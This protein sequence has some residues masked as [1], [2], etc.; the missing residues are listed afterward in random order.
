MTYTATRL[1]EV[2]LVGR[3]QT[4]YVLLTPGLP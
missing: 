4:Y 2:K 3:S 1:L